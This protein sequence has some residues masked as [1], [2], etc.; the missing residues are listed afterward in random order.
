MM[1][2]E[3]FFG[4]NWLSGND[5]SGGKRVDV[6]ILSAEVVEFEARNN[7]PAENR[8]VLGFEG[9]EKRLVLNK[10]RGRKMMELFGPESSEWI[11][12]RV[13]LSAAPSFNGMLT[14]VISPSAE[15]PTGEIPF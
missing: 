8:V 5:F 11:G 3:S 1:N 15:P 9:K 2:V 6:T 13:N 4:S 7:L 10:T 12:K 14:V